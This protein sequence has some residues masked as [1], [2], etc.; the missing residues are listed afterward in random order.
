MSRR[1]N[2]DDKAGLYITVSVHLVVII[3]LLATQIGYT[4]RKENSFVLDFSRLEERERLAE[5]LKLTEDSQKKLE[6]LLAAAGNVQYQAEPI[7]N[8]TVNAGL[9]DDRGTNADELYKEAERLANE[10]K[11]GQKNT[12]DDP[13]DFADIS[14]NK[15]QNKEETKKE[16][17]TG[18]SVLSWTLDSRKASRLPI[19]A[20][21]CMGG[22]T[23]TVIIT[24]D[25]QG[26][27]V[28]VKVQDEVS[29]TDRC[30]RDFATRA[31]RMSK[32]SASSTAPAKQMGNIVYS[33]IAQ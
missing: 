4:I 1:L 26:N 2:N 15:Q 30:L 19:P 8:V 33:F 3:I 12:L 22:G 32:F 31:A 14:S 6:E 29:S 10:L 17:Y 11:D 9:K 23:V 28:A 18:P 27:V 13:D 21:R 5:Q 16:V 20:Y 25:N 7:R 24:V